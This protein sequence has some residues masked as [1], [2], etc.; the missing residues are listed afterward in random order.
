MAYQKLQASR[1]EVVI[2]SDTANIPDVAGGDNLG[3]TLYV[4]TP[5]DLRVLTAGLDDVTFVGFAGGFLPVQV[6]RVFATGTAADDI[7]ALW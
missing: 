7:L 2:K 6:L 5:G 1:A 3:C 4:G